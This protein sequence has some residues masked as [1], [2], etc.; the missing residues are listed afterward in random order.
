MKKVTIL[1]VDFDNITMDDLILRLNNGGIVFTP[2]VDHLI[3]LQYQKEFY[4]S[5]QQADY[6]V[7]DSQVLVLVSKLLGK[8]IVEKVSG[9]DLFPAFCSHY[10]K[11]PSMK[12]FLLGAAPGVALKAMK[13]INQRLGSRM[14]V[15][16]HSPSFGFENN[17]DECMEIIKMINGSGANVLAVGVG[18]PKQENWIVKNKPLMPGIKVFFAIGATLDF[19]AG[20]IRRSPKWISKIGFEWFYRMLS[21][22]ARLWKRYLVEDLPFFRMVIK[23]KLGTYKNPWA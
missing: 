2:N 1:N 13:N 20:N 21:D 19:E 17:P 23:Q 4:L 10:C 8:S 15:Y 16:A 18:A 5:Y 9:S 22:P 11:D 7:C 6:R 14:I 3:K 12:I